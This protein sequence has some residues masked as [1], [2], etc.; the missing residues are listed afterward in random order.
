MKKYF[1]LF[2]LPLLAF[3]IIEWTTVNLDDRVS[4]QFPST[5]T[6]SETRGNPMWIADIDTN[7]RCMALLVDLGKMGLDSAT[8]TPMLEQDAF[9]EQF[10]TSTINSI[11]DVKFVEER[12]FK[13]D[14]RY[15]YEFVL[16]KETPDL[17]F[18]Y[19]RVYIRSLF[20]GTRIYS[21]S[22]FQKQ[23]ADDQR[24]KFFESV[25]VQY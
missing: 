5:P 22:F 14:G 9:Y 4:V 13:I 11:G 16:E 12:K 3:G 6:S 8:F 2:L 25:R 24:Q 21:L 19:K 23:P 20:L 7:S 1:I 15:A 17:K 10:K 18:N